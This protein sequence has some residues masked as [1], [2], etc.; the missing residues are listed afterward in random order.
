VAGVPK[1]ME[2]QAGT[3][4]PKFRELERRVYCCASRHCD[5]PHRLRGQGAQLVR[6]SLP[7]LITRV[8]CRERGAGGNLLASCDLHNGPN[9]VHNDLRLVYRDH[10]TGLLSRHHTPSF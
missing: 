8:V 7:R 4:D 6:E 3:G 9:R 5:R 1:S 10:V 2:A